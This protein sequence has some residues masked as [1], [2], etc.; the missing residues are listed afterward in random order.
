MPGIHYAC[1]QKEIS[2]IMTLKHP[3]RGAQALAEKCYH[4][5]IAIL[6]QFGNKTF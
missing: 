4:H 6:E 5:L 2:E 1:F 3:L